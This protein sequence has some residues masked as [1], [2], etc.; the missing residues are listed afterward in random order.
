MWVDD[1]CVYHDKCVDG[2]CVS[3]YVM[4]IG[5]RNSCIWIYMGVNSLMSYCI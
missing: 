3:L 1:K 2:G 4:L 5:T